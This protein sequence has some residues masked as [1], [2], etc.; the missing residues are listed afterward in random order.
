MSL[1]QETIKHYDNMINVVE[2]MSEE[3]RK[4]SAQV[5]IMLEMINESWRSED[6]PYCKEYRDYS[7][8]G[9][10]EPIRLICGDCPY[11][12]K[13]GVCGRLGNENAW[14]AMNKAKTWEE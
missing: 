9:T 13:Y 10:G 6:C 7:M 14:F 1:K 5:F 2:N 8:F 3:E 11:G 4:A 12:K